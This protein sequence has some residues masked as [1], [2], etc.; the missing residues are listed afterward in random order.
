[1]VE[2][3]DMF[4]QTIHDSI[5]YLPEDNEYVISVM[6]EEFRK[7]GIE[8]SLRGEPLCQNTESSMTHVVNLSQL[9]CETELLQQQPKKKLKTKSMIEGVKQLESLQETLNQN[10]GIHTCLCSGLRQ[11][12]L[13]GMMDI[14]MN[15]DVELDEVFLELDR[16]LKECDSKEPQVLKAKKVLQNRISV[17]KS[18]KDNYDTEVR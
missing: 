10:V 17:A 2:K 15:V 11:S 8:P 5:C 6:R 9:I 7:I 18:E 14:E 16:L 3:P 12:N 13:G 4:M 1:M